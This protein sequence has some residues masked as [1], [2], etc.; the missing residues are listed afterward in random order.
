[1]H[2]NLLR[3]LADFIQPGHQ[4][5]LNAGLARMLAAGV[6]GGLTGGGGT[7][8]QIRFGGGTLGLLQA[9]HQQA[10][11]LARAFVL[12]AVAALGNEVVKHRYRQAHL[13]FDIGFGIFQ[14]D[15]VVFNFGLHHG[16]QWADHR[17]LAHRGL[18]HVGRG[19]RAGVGIDRIGADHGH[20]FGPRQ[21]I[22]GHVQC[23]LATGIGAPLGFAGVAESVG[24]GVQ[25]NQ[26]VAD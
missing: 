15:V 10:R 26:G 4:I 20:Q 11:K 8:V 25:A 18:Q 6:G 2:L 23:H 21:G 7:G 5:V 14:G 24:I 3:K 13:L 22:G 19:D 9:D 1:M 17:R 12:R 16:R